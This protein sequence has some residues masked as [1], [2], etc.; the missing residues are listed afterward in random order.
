L[1]RPTTAAEPL[2]REIVHDEQ[3]SVN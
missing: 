1:V 3:T 2:L